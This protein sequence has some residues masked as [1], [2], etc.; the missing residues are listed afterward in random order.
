M[1][2]PQHTCDGL[3]YSASDERIH[4]RG[5]APGRGSN[6]PEACDERAGQAAAA[7]EGM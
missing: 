2:D 3:S 5:P 1:G 6:K 7:P 4:Y